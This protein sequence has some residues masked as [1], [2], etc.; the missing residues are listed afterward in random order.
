[1]S[2]SAVLYFMCGKMAAGKSTLAKSL[3]L[4][5]AAVL[6]SEDALLSELYP[7]E[8]AGLEDYARLSGRVKR[9]LTGHICAL[10]HHGVSVVLDFPANTVGQR[11]WFRELIDASGAVHELHFL[12]VPDEICKRQL[13]AR[14]ESGADD[15]LQDEAT[16]D[17]LATYFVPP[18]ADESFTVVRHART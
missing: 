15:P 7:G 1:M 10:L 12:E 18:A 13:K 16:F 17:L 8:I 4:A 5:N 3:H 2:R 11:L 6:L 14:N 9:A